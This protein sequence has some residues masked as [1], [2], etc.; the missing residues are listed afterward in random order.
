MWKWLLVTALILGGGCIGTGWYMQS[1]GKFDEWQRQ[2][3]PDLRPVTVRT[4]KVVRGDLVR[5]VNTPGKVEPRT[6]VE[7]SA[8]V[9][10]ASW[11]CRSARARR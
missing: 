11:R 10:A 1:T 8:Q 6:K 4:A 5:T 9:S 2:F 7:I 3:R